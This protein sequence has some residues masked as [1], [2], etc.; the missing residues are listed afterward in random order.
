MTISTNYNCIL[1]P[2]SLAAIF[3]LTS[4]C[5][6]FKRQPNRVEDILL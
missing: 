5:E 3:I 4:N 6:L 2:K 1:S